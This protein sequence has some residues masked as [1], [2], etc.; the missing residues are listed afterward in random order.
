MIKRTLSLVARFFLTGLL[1]ALF[2]IGYFFYGVLWMFR[3]MMT[4]KKTLLFTIGITCLLCAGAGSYYLFMPL[5]KDG[6]SITIIVPRGCGAHGVA[7]SLL[8]HGI[9]SS[10]TA[11]LLWFKFG[12]HSRHIQAGKYLFVHKQ[13]VLAA[14][15]SL[16]NPVPL[17]TTIIVPEGLT[18]E[19]TAGR[20]ATAYPFDT[21]EIIR[22]CYDTAF[23]R[24]LGFDG[25]S[26][27]EGYL[28]P[29]TYRFLETATPKDIV[30]RMVDRFNE[31][32]AAVDTVNGQL[33]KKEI[34]TLASI[35]EKEA[36]LAVERPRIAGV[37]VNRLTLH[38]PL[39]AD[40]TVRFA[41]KKFN[42]PLYLSDLA[43]KSPYNTRRFKGLPPGPI[44]SPGRASLIAAISP[45]K[46][47]ELYFVARWDG[48]G[49]HD[50]S[51]TGEEHSRKKLAIRRQNEKRLLNKGA[52]CAKQ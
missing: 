21:A 34:V 43:I 42:G 3:F 48:T 14:S 44:C 19:Q 10:R 8:R 17:D 51:V 24:S 2:L 15:R 6:K 20:I 32:W 23:I 18:I 46:T 28:F 7:D 35:V 41:L 52:S 29:D 33:T 12:G 1:F 26:S 38:E 45:M 13:G 30:R 36:T 25:V 11:F 50:F 27:L 39:G 22:L 5:E 4:G 49:A 16:R 47:N 40:P 9:I 37:F 31:A